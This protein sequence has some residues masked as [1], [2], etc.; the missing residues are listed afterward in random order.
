MSAEK[1]SDARSIELMCIDCENTISF[2]I[3]DLEAG[4]RLTCTQCGKQY[5]FNQE[6]SGK[7]KRFEYLLAAVYNARDILG[8][9]N[10][11]IAFRDEEVKVPYRLLLTR[12]NTLLTLNVNGK[13]TTFRFRVEPLSMIDER[14]KIQVSE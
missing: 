14:E 12:L 9:A 5:M 1:Y 13:E 3:L 2:S 7:I 4:G 6:L 11:A 10:V 8:S